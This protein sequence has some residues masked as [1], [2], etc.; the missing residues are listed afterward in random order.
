M[1]GL[2]S[3]ERFSAAGLPAPGSRAGTPPYDV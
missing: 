2:G 3:V 1:R